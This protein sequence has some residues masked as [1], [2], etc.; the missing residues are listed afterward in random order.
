MAKLKKIITLI[1]LSLL[2][3]CLCFGCTQVPKDEIQANLMASKITYLK[4]E[5]VTE[6]YTCLDILNGKSRAIKDFEMD[7]TVR[8]VG[9][10]TDYQTIHYEKTLPY[11]KSQPA[12]F[13][14]YIQGKVDSIEIT[15][16]RFNIFTYWQTFGKHIITT[17]L[18]YIVLTVLLFIFNSAEMYGLMVLISAGSLIFGVIYTLFMPFSQAVFVLVGTIISLIPYLVYKYGDSY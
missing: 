1:V 13:T 6:V 18:I 14:F 11:M 12:I 7:I 2:V 3:S 15:A 5:G 9:G 10:G 4:S 8:Y 17:A 16:F